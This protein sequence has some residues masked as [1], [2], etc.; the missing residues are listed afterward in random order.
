MIFRI[1][2]SL[3]FFLGLLPSPAPADDWPW[4]RGTDRNGIAAPD[5]NPPTEF[6]DSKN[7]RW[8]SPVPGRGHG[9]VTAVGDK[10][11]LLTADET[12]QTQSVLCYSRETGGPLWNTEVH[13]GGFPK[14]NKKASHASTTPACDGERVFATFVSG[15]AAHLNAL[16]LDGKILWQKEICKYV[17]HQGY[18]SSP[19][20]YEHLVIV[21]A[22]NKKGGAIC[23]Y[24]RE[25]GEEA[26]RVARPKK[27][28]YASPAILNVAGKVQLLFTGCDLVSSFDP[29][30][31]EKNWEIEGATTE[32][33]TTTVTD[34]ERIFTSGGYPKNHVSAIEA[35]GSGKTAWE[36]ISRVY[37]PSMLVKDGYLYAVMDGG[38]AV[39][40]KCDTGERKWR[41]RLNGTFSSSPVLVGDHI[42]AA[43]EIGEFFVFKA[44]PE[45]FE[46]V[47]TNRLGDE[48]FATPTIVDGNIFARVMV[49]DAKGEKSGRLYCIELKP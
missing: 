39:C 41:G 14:T 31:G 23:A 15:G 37:V 22:D 13:R 42:Y 19:A 43:N 36:N 17:V 45:T 47:A 18:G 4:W 7:V 11:F 40:W 12:E 26:W 20:I 1:S 8:V 38:I 29:L 5:Q 21:S 3:F 46:I 10:L 9:S 2:L 27:P 6:S 48:A 28:N 44:D 34:G 16:D 30:T 25:T 32:C 35:D 49:K 33:V 24:H